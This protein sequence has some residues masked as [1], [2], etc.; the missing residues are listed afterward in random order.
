M[1]VL[2]IGCMG[3]NGGAIS[4]AAALEE[5]FD[6]NFHWTIIRPTTTFG[7]SRIPF[8]YACKR[9]T[10]TLYNRILDGKPLVRFDE[11]NS[12]H[13]ICHTVIGLF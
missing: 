3:L 9:H 7:D 11:L 6:C 4:E 8:E 2:I 13:A 1:R 10:Y 5:M 12:R